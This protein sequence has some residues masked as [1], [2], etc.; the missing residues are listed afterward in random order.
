MEPN[1]CRLDGVD[2]LGAM[3]VDLW[4]KYAKSNKE[5]EIKGKGSKKECGGNRMKGRAGIY[6]AQ[7]IHRYASTKDPT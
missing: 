4:G 7:N 3:E 1:H 2:F 6:R 5:N